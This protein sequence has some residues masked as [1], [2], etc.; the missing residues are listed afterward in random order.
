MA[1][2]YLDNVRTV[3]LFGLPLVQPVAYIDSRENEVDV[4]PAGGVYRT[5]GDVQQ[6]GLRCRIRDSSRTQLS[7]FR[8]RFRNVLYGAAGIFS[9]EWP[10]EVA[11]HSLS[12]NA[13]VG[14]EAAADTNVVMFQSN[15]SSAIPEGRWVQFDNHRKLYELDASARDGVTFYP[16]LVEAVPAGTRLKYRGQEVLWECYEVTGGPVEWIYDDQGIIAHDFHFLEKIL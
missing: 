2:G 9:F 12:A 1:Q 6:Y 4:S 3:H 5:I 7:V 16:N 10:Q 8:R 14:A 13:V 11:E 15:L